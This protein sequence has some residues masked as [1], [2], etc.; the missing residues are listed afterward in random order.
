MRI[1]TLALMG[2]IAL[3]SAVD[4]SA[5]TRVKPQ[6]PTPPAPTFQKQAPKPDFLILH[7]SAIGGTTNQFM[8]QVK[9][10]GAANAP[11]ALLQSVN[12]ANGN[13][14]AATTPVPPIKAGQFV[15]VKVELNK[16]A[17][18]GDR[19]L[20]FADHNNAVAEIKETNNKYGFNF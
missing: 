5:Q 4:A 11:G 17:R 15:W 6:Q 7:A 19:I 13:S 8:V 2:A 16:R 20:L 14:G 12:M 1:V 18:P 9:N 10:A 3:A